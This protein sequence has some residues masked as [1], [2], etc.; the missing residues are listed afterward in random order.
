MG[1]YLR[2]GDL[3]IAETGTSAYGIPGASIMTK[4]DMSMYTQTVFGS[5]GFAAGAAVGSFVA[6]RE[7]K[8]K[9]RPILI[10]GEGSLQLTVQAFSD[11]LR[12]DLGSTIF[13]LNNDGYTV[14]RLIHGPHAAYNKVPIWD[15][16]QLAA[17][18][19]PDKQ[20]AGKFRHYLIKNPD[21][22]EKLFQDPF[23]TEKGPH[24]GVTQVVEILLDALDA[25]K[26]VL[27]V[28]AAIEEFN[29]TKIH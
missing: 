14:E 20:K 3:V 16:S 4:P 28:T 26:G 11:L 1:R 24:S 27:D 9:G 17:L 21:E 18:F 25:P 22:L 10:T 6:M 23:F 5:I 2:S 7:L 12:H 8:Y 15:Y 19:A 29:R 13:L